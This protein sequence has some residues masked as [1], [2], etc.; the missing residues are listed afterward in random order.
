[1]VFRDFVIFLGK[2]C[3]ESLGPGCGQVVVPDRG[4]NPREILGT[5]RPSIR[6]IQI[7]SNE[8]VGKPKFGILLQERRHLIASQIRTDHIR[9]GLPDLEQ[10]RAE[11]G[12]IRCD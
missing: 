8:R 2:V 12:D 7:E 10:I 1:M 11:I 6:G 5:R 9:F 3:D 4:P